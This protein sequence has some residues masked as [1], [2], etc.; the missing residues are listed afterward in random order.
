VNA[1]HLDDLRGESVIAEYWRGGTFE[2]GRDSVAVVALPCGTEAAMILPTT[3]RWDR[4]RPSQ[5]C[6]RSGQRRAS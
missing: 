2:P 6:S 5:C 1:Q 3:R 4:C